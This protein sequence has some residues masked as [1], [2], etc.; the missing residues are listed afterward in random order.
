MMDLVYWLDS[1]IVLDN[2]LK[3]GRG[4]IAIDGEII[5]RRYGEAEK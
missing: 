2:G 4:L 5:E 3:S 1:R